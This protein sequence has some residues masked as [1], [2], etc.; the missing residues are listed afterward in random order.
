MSAPH[1]ITIQ[2]SNKVSL[3][4]SGSVLSWL[5]LL[6]KRTFA[7]LLLP[8]YIVRMKFLKI[9]H[10]LPHVWITHTVTLSVRPSSSN[11]GLVFGS[12]CDS[13]CRPVQSW[14][15]GG[16]IFLLRFDVSLVIFRVVLI[17]LTPE[18]NIKLEIYPRNLFSAWSESARLPSM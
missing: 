15:G 5:L 6:G 14:P 16:A 1:S 7:H 18:L 2:R 4:C 3:Q 8:V 11:P 17:T 10:V 9:L 13:I 12:R